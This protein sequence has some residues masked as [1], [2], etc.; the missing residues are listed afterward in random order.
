MQS[1][2]AGL[3]ISANVDLGGNQIWT[4]S[5]TNAMTVGGV[6]SGAFNLTKAGTGTLVLTGNNTFS[7]ALTVQEGTLSI[8]TINNASSNG[9]LGNSAGAVTLG[10][11]T[12]SGTL[13]YTGATALSTKP[14]ALAA[15]GGQISLLA[16]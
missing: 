5:S 13:E 3:S 4:N 8:P 6:I 2:A 16:A 15:G 1:G 9:T 10:G 12:T 14:F 11:A 7:G